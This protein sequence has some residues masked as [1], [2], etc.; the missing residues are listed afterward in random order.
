MK[1]REL[2]RMLQFCNQDEELYIKDVGADGNGQDLYQKVTGT[3]VIYDDEK[4][5]YILIITD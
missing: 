5:S 4:D 3:D 2:V 1:V